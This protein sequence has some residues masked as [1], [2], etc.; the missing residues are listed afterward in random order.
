MTQEAESSQSAYSA[1]RRRAS[2]SDSWEEGVGFRN[3]DVETLSRQEMLVFKLK[4]EIASVGSEEL[5]SW[6]EDTIMIC[7]RK[8][9]DIAK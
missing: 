2:V 1:E 5:A 4:S 6:A 7:Y 3:Y 9:E 8:S